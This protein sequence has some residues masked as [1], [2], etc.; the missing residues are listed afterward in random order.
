MPYRECFDRL[1]NPIAR[2]ERVPLWHRIIQVAGLAAIVVLVFMLG[3][4][5]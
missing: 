2:P 3:G 4:R 5:L 1:G